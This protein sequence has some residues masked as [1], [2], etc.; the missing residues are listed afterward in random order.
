MPVMFRVAAALVVALGPAPDA[1]ESTSR[2]AEPADAEPAAADI[3]MVS[4]EVENAECL[5]QWLVERWGEQFVSPADISK[6]G[7]NRI[8]DADTARRLLTVL[9]RNGSVVRVTEPTVI[10]GKLR[11]EAYRILEAEK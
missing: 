6:S 1:P 3:T 8:R 10:K 9:E 7:P 2:D 5:R 11:R 4:P